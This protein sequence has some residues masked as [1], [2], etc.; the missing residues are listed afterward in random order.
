MANKERRDDQ[1][2]YFSDESIF[3]KQKI[4][5]KKLLKLNFMDCFDFNRIGGRQE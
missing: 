4:C 2:A 1:M 5:G 3:Q